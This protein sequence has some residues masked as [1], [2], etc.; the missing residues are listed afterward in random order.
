MFFKSNCLEAVKSINSDISRRKWGSYPILSNIK[1]SFLAFR[2]WSWTSIRITANETA[3][4]L[5]ELAKSRMYNEVWAYRPPS[6]F[7]FILNRDGL[8][9]VLQQ[10]FSLMLSGRLMDGVVLVLLCLSSSSP[11][12]HIICL[13]FCCPPLWLELPGLLLLHVFLDLAS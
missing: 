6:S 2:Y 10:M 12:L 9:G 1:D 4:N 3:D 8:F 13:W 11:S 7:T 5:A